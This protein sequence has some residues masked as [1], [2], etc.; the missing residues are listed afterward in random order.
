MDD[1]NQGLSEYLA[2]QPCPPETDTQRY[3]G[4]KEGEKLYI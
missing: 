2:R 3:A 4:W 1:W